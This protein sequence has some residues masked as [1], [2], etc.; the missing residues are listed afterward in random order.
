MS[1]HCGRV[2]SH[3]FPWKVIPSSSSSIDFP[4][5]TL[6]HT[7]WQSQLESGVAHCLGGFEQAVVWD[8]FNIELELYISELA[9][10][11]FSQTDT[12]SYPVYQDHF[13]D[14]FHVVFPSCFPQSPSKSLLLQLGELQ[15]PSVSFFGNF[16]L[17]DKR[18]L[19]YSHICLV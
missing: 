5:H 1:S 8:R 14:C 7:Q 6:T 19:I 15:G 12:K 11:Q 2:S 10:C 3:F 9:Q 18:Q 17:S 13:M 4:Q 16:M